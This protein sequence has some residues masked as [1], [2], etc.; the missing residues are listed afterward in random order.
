[1]HQKLGC[2]HAFAAELDD[3]LADRTSTRK[4][5]AGNSD[6]RE[7]RAHDLYLRGRQLLLQFRRQGF[8]R[9]RELFRRALALDP[10]FGLAHSGLADCCSYLYLYWEPTLENLR[11]ADSA[12]RRAVELN[13][14][15][16]ESHVSR[17]IALSTL[18]NY[19]EAEQ[20][21]QFAI[22]KDPEHFDARYFQGR[23]WMAQ[24][25]F[26]EAIGPLCSACELRDD[27]YQAPTLLAMAYTGCGRRQEASC[28]FE[29]AVE[30]ARQQL[31]VN[32]GDLRA[33]YLGAGCLA[34]LGRRRTAL[35]WAAR[36]LD[37][38][39][40]DS[41][42]LYNVGCVY[43]ILGRKA[44]ALACLKRVVR[45]GWRK[46]W[47]RHDPDWTALRG[48]KQFAALVK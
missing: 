42:V 35:A 9:A 29:R 14:S 21:F 23:A 20:E 22:E 7:R 12:S 27:D 40:K 36:A 48:L 2:I 13:P 4:G 37:L 31:A 24:G 41:S 19:P 5:M 33:L 28:A 26:T 11:L 16:A 46:E 45:S 44:E 25:K 18:R 32:P 17:A 3:W 10:D 6:A 8:E 15:I 43:A 1:M 34:R 38:D 39:G 47:I 30:I